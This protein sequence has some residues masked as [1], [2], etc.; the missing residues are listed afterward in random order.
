MPVR[1][2]SQLEKHHLK[3]EL[4]HNGFNSDEDFNDVL[5]LIEQGWQINILGWLKQKHE[6]QRDHPNQ[7]FIRG[8]WQTIQ[9]A[10]NWTNN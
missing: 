1:K 6:N 4:K 5:Q 2:L 3:L 7:I 10:L 9:E 8:K